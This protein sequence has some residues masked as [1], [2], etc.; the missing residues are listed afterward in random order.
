MP[1]PKPFNATTL[2]LTAAGLALIGILTL[3]ARPTSLPAGSV[4]SGASSGQSVVRA[5]T[6]NSSAANNAAGTPLSIG[7]K[8]SS[9]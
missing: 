9:T 4:S 5:N 3:A 7:P 2:I 1:S 8:S 6:L